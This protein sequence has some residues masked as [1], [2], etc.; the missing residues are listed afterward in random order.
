MQG[1][2]SM[3]YLYTTAQDMLSVLQG[4]AIHSIIVISSLLSLYMPRKISHE[5]Q[6]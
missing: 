4:M 5:I 1:L 2:G 6:L 3:Q